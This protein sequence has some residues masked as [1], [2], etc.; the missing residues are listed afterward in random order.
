MEELWGCW[1]FCI[2]WLEG[3]NEVL[4][5]NT[6]LEKSKVFAGTYPI[7]ICM[8]IDYTTQEVR[9]FF[10]KFKLAFRCSLV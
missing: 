8:K 5:R 2:G 3:I 4:F 6:D 7:Q 9:G 10:F 1:S